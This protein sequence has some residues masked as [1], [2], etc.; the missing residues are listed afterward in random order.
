MCRL[1]L[2]PATAYRRTRPHRFAGIE[3]VDISLILS[4]AHLPVEAVLANPPLWAQKV[5]SMLAERGLALADVNFT[6]GGNFQTRSVNHPDAQVRREA[7]EW[8]YR[9]LEFTVRANGKHMTLLP[10]TCWPV[11]DGETSLKR[12]AD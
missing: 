10:G 1:Q 6:P 12:S 11:E 5:S 2:P 7:R 9:A 4:N 3:G 8:F